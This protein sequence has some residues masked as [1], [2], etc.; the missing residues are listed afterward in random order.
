MDEK[1]EIIPSQGRTWLF[2]QK[3]KGISIDKELLNKLKLYLKWKKNS[4]NEMKALKT[5]SLIS[6]RFNHNHEMIVKVDG[7]NEK[8]R[9]SAEQAIEWHSDKIAKQI[10]S[11]ISV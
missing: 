1:N 9:I 8:K 6:H 4:T 3:P 11:A 7:K 2:S 10:S 5:N